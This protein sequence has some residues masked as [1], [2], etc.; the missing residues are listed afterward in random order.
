MTIIFVVDAF[1]I[2]SETFILNQITGLMDMGHEVL[3]FSAHRSDESSC[4]SDV[5]RYELL[6]RTYYHNEMPSSKF[7][8]IIWALFMIITY[9]HRNPRAI[10]NSLNFFKYGKEALS[11][12]YLYKVMLFLGVKKADIIF[13][14]YGPNGNFGARMKELGIAGKLVTMFHGYDLRRGI[15]QKDLY[16]LLFSRVDALLSISSYNNKH[17]LSFGAPKERIHQHPVGIDIESYAFKKYS[18][19]PP[20]NPIRILTV[21]RLV[22]EKGISDG[23]SAIHQLVHERGLTQIQYDIIGDGPLR[24][25]LE[26]LVA[27]LNLKDNVHFLGYAVQ[28]SVIRMLNESHIFFLPSIAEALPVV[29]MEAQ[30]VGLPVVATDVGSVREVVLDGQSGFIV[31]SKDIKAMSDRLEHLI[32]YPQEWE[33]MGRK[34]H[35]HIKDHYS[36]KVLNLRLVDLFKRL[37]KK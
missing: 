8:R 29:L 26:V 9:G 32:R 10:F 17:L 22:E 5:R 20:D 24:E 34:G 2:I 16:K 28:E 14:H 6:K 23:L 19:V 1:P 11:L 21:S 35:Q 4:H 7:K 30:S 15:E 27:K 25:E 31:P 18:S 3:I 12:N 37:L 36:I 33:E 13:C